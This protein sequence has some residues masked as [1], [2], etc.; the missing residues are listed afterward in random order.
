MSVNW[1]KK[2]GGGEG[3]KARK[4]NQYKKGW[5]CDSSGRVPALSKTF[6]PTP[7]AIMLQ[8]HPASHFQSLCDL[9]HPVD[10]S[11]PFFCV[12]FFSPAF[13]LSFFVSFISLSLFLNLSFKC[14]FS[15]ALAS[16]SPLI[17]H[18]L[19][20]LLTSSCGS[21]IFLAQTLLSSKP[22]HPAATGFLAS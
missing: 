20:T 19:P 11:L 17:P 22:K 12:F 6:S 9:I 14:Q 1:K 2:K 5:G 8:E 3:S 21:H 13:D 16:V 7:Y 4:N 10:H 15:R 18:Y